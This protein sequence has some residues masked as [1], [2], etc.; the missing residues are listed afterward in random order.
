MP[1]RREKTCSLGK[2]SVNESS[3]RAMGKTKGRI[4]N[5][6]SLGCSR[7]G[8]SWPQVCVWHFLV[9]WT[10]EVLNP[11]HMTFDKAQE[12]QLVENIE[13]ALGVPSQQ[14]EGSC[15][16]TSR[17]WPTTL[18]QWYIWSCLSGGPCHGHEVQPGML[19]TLYSQSDDTQEWYHLGLPKNNAPLSS[20]LYFIEYLMLGV[21]IHTVTDTTMT[22]PN[23]SA[24]V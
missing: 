5:Q 6:A 11:S 4:W 18:P 19:P 7:R 17:C 15:K 2:Q 13:V 14:D 24:A 22:G 12:W 1:I 10:L 3:Q 23:A 9:Q 8:W 16:L 20:P 21:S